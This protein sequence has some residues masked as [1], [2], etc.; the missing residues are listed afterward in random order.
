MAQEQVIQAKERTKATR[1]RV[2]LIVG[3][4]AAMFLLFLFL[5]RDNNKD[6]ADTSVPAVTSTTITTATTTTAANPTTTAAVTPSSAVAEKLPEAIATKPVVKVPSGPAPK[7]LQKT[8]LVVGTGPA[9]TEGSDV[10]VNYVGVSYSTKEEF[11]TSWGREPFPVQNV[12]QAQ[13][14]D[15]WNQGLVGMKEGGRR[16]LIIPADLAYGPNSPSPQIAPNETLIFVVDALKVT[17]KS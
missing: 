9:V 4:L 3:V 17:P 11:D 7:T 8:D 6:T 14:I 16:Q 1:N 15:G 13:V 10:V 12:G 2:L 5:S